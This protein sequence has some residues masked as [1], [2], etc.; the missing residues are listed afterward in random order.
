MKNIKQIGNLP[1]IIVNAAD[2]SEHSTATLMNEVASHTS[3]QFGRDFVIYD[4]TQFTPT[5][6]ELDNWVE[7]H[8][9]GLR[10]SLTDPTVFA[11]LVGSDDVLH[12]IADYL[13]DLTHYIGVYDDVGDAV[14]H[15]K[16]GYRI[17]S[18]W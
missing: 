2:A 10:G 13:G 12:E 16:E 4:C 1:V 8:G 15:A 17:F 14:R 6:D 9:A 3:G 7:L 18:A 11:I 5:A